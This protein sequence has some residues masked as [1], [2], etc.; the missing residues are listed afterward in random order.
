[1]GFKPQTS[2][3]AKRP[4]D[5]LRHYHGPNN[6]LTFEGVAGLKVPTGYG[7]LQEAMS[8]L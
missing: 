2:G 5:P 4:L 8:C 7:N 3:I 6:A 1:M